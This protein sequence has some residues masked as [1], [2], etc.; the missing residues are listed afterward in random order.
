[1]SAFRGI[2]GMRQTNLQPSLEYYTTI[3]NTKAILNIMKKYLN[4][5]VK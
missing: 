5:I 2:A 4:Y 3:R 1:M